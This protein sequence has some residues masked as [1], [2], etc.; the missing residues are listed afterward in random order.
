MS[1]FSA[2]ICCVCCTADLDRQHHTHPSHCTGHRLVLGTSFPWDASWRQTRPPGILCVSNFVASQQAIGHCPFAC[3]RSSIVNVDY[4]LFCVLQAEG[5]PVHLSVSRQRAG[6]EER[7][8]R[9]RK[10]IERSCF[11][12]VKPQLVVVPPSDAHS[13][14]GMKIWTSS[15][16]LSEEI[17]LIFYPSQQLLVCH[18]APWIEL[19]Y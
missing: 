9:A 4:G 3:E 11:F 10:L 15:I 12:H 14:K 17:N 7:W 16:Y 19:C 2:L 8:R 1:N 5:C 6:R 13:K 18:L